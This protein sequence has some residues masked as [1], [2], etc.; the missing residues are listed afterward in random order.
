MLVDDLQHK[1]EL[2]QQHL[3]EMEASL[4]GGAQVDHPAS[5]LEEEISRYRGAIAKLERE[6]EFN[7][8]LVAFMSNLEGLAY[9]LKERESQGFSAEEKREIKQEFLAPT[10]AAYQALISAAEAW[11]RNAIP[12]LQRQ[13][14]RSSVRSGNKGMN[15]WRYAGTSCGGR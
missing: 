6:R 11:R 5:A 15:A 8:A 4:N 7:Q 3:A 13:R 1:I 14:T 2:V 12:M 10:Q 9:G